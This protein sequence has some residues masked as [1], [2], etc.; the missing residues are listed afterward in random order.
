MYERK[1]TVK[2]VMFVVPSLGGGGAERVVVN[3]I[4]HLN[5]ERYSFQLVVF[6]K[7]GDYLGDLPTY[8]EVYSLKKKIHKTP[9]LQWLIFTELAKVFNKVR[10]DI[11]ISFMWYPNVISLIS[12]FISKHK[13]PVLI[14]ERYSIKGS[15]EG[16]IIEFLRFLSIKMFYSKCNRLI[17][18]SK[19]M[20]QQFIE[21][22][23]MPSKKVEVIYNPVDRE[24][25]FK[26]SREPLEEEYVS[27]NKI[28]VIIGIGRL[29]PQKGFEYLIKATHILI[30]KGLNLRLVILGKGHLK[31]ELKCLASK[32]KLNDRVLF[33]GFQRN[34]Y[35]YLA[36]STVFVLSS[37]YEGF[38]NALLE[39]MALG[40][41]SVATRCPTGPE[42]LITDGVDGIL[43]PPR[44]EKALASAIERLL[45]DEKLRV[46]LGANARRKAE[47]FDVKRIVKEYER[48]L[49]QIY[50][51]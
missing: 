37:L 48:V 45:K 18:N 27:F 2:K 5:K 29:T 43:V 8:V 46:Q 19:E 51:E 28:P 9:G 44:D 20:K 7:S 33:L 49:E 38:P 39:A 25:I 4:R 47:A 10:P 6:D 35:K 42:E 16:R 41:P 3:I 30:Q 1:E 11:V 40:V 15:S 50:E 12:R 14:S 32:L 34:P 13:P 21:I 17:V 24:K 22:F 31:Q 26:L 23:N 36:S